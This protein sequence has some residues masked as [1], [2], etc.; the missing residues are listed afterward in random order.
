MVRWSGG[1]NNVVKVVNM[2]VNQ[3]M[4]TNVNMKGNE[5]GERELHAQKTDSRLLLKQACDPCF[6]NQYVRTPGPEVR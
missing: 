1:V 4:N 3:T 5:T 6:P 2:N